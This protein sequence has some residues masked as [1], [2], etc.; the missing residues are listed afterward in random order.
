MCRHTTMCVGRRGPIHQAH[1]GLSGANTGRR[2]RPGHSLPQGLQ[3]DHLLTPLPMSPSL[4]TWDRMNSRGPTAPGL[5]PCYVLWQPQGTQG[6]RKNY[7]DSPRSMGTMLR[8]PLPR[9]RPVV[10]GVAP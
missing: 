7:C 9:M 10:Y 2:K 3:K 4:R 8:G 5:W 1:Q 6:T